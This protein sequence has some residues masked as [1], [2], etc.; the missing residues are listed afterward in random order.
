M[1]EIEK[2]YLIELS[3]WEYKILSS[4]ELQNVYTTGEEFDGFSGIYIIG[5]ISEIKSQ[6]SKIKELEKENKELS[7]NICDIIKISKSLKNEK[8][9][10]YKSYVEESI[11]ELSSK[12]IGL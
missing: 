1:E 8:P 10:Y 12:L 5:E 3:D 6:Q 4:E 11:K 7:K 2:Q 9:F